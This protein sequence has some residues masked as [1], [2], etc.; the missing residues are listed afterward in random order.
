MKASAPGA[1]G[2]TCSGTLVAPNLVLTARHCVDQSTNTQGMLLCGVDQFTTRTSTPAQIWVTTGSDMN[3]GTAG[4]HAVSEIHTPNVTPSEACSTDIALLV[5]A[6]SVAS[7]EAKPADL[8]AFG[9]MTDHSR[10]STE[11]TLLGFGRSDPAVLGSL[12][13]RRIVEHALITCIPGDPA[14]RDA[15][16]MSGGVGPAPDGG[17]ND[18]LD[19]AANFSV[20]HGGCPGDSGGGAYE[21]SAFTEGVPLVMGVQSRGDAQGS[22]CLALAFTRTDVWRD[23]LVATAKLASQS[24]GYPLPAWALGRTIK[25]RDAGALAPDAARLPEEAGGGAGQQAC[26]HASDCPE[27]ACVAVSG[28]PASCVP[29]CGPDRTCASENAI[30]ST[31]DEQDVCLAA[32]VTTSTEFISSEK[33]TG[34]AIAPGVPARPRAGLGLLLSIVLAI[35]VAARRRALAV[36]ALAAGCGGTSTVETPNTTSQKSSPEARWVDEPL[37][38]DA[39]PDVDS[40][41]CPPSSVSYLLG[42]WMPRKPP[43]DVPTAC[44]AGQTLAIVTPCELKVGQC[45]DFG[46]ELAACVYCLYGR[47]T[48][49]SYALR[50]NIEGSERLNVRGYALLAGAG[51]TCA[52]ALDDFQGCM[53]LAC[54]CAND[55]RKAA[56]LSKARNGACVARNEGV[57][58]ACSTVASMQTAK[59]LR[60]I[61]ETGAFPTEAAAVTMAKAFCGGS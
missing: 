8:L 18:N 1:C 25:P 61:I 14:F 20:S 51:A 44:G 32:K 58:A 23:F 13:Q 15:Y 5:L 6:D 45:R 40:G 22:V 35:R 34:C 3:A 26:R 52:E 46:V 41:A 10:Y 47:E 12:G 31:I 7:S 48:D 33:E 11:V 54:D 21:Q 49:A 17:T 42:S 56:C 30:C 53:Q 27:G 24:G 37:P 19:D 39:G 16:C 36:L 9:P 50:S 59:F 60:P 4:W 29:R 38:V 43:R 55:A 28:A 2:G 57:T